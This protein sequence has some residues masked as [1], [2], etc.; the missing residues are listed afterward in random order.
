MYTYSV[1]HCLCDI[2]IC[3]L[4]YISEIPELTFNTSDNDIKR[5]I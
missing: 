2:E 5:Y 3:L 1:L 4:K